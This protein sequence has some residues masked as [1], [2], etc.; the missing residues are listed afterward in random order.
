MW[1]WRACKPSMFM[2]Y[3][4][5]VLFLSFSFLSLV[6]FLYI[7][8]ACVNFWCLLC[9][10]GCRVIVHYCSSR[11][12]RILILYANQ[13]TKEPTVSALSSLLKSLQKDHSIT[14]TWGSCIIYIHNFAFW[15]VPLARIRQRLSQHGTR[16]VLVFCTLC[17]MWKV[18]NFFRGFY[19]A[20]LVQFKKLK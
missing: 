9:I 4:C 10:T 17:E 14:P 12:L 7:E 8:L 5:Q 13:G 11:Q 18:A 16:L 15:K 20:P 3:P 2:H 1:V 19:F 6:N